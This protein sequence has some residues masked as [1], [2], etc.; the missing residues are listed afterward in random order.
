[1]R[2]FTKGD[3]LSSFVARR[4]RCDDGVE[5]SVDLRA[6]LASAVTVAVATHSY[7]IQARTIQAQRFR[8]HDSG[9]TRFRP[10]TIQA[11]NFGY[12][13]GRTRFRPITIQAQYARFRS[14]RHDSGP[15]RFRPGTIQAEHDSGRAQFRPILWVL[16]HIWSKP[17]SRI[18]LG[19]R[20]QLG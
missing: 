17:Q 4:R 11:E 8:P 14:K 15:S 2:Y 12:D 18:F 1:M 16:N 10:N 19:S 6:A 9:R 13:S 3:R 7:S 5:F 20:A